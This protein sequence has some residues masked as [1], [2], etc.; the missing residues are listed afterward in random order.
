MPARRV[1]ERPGLGGHRPPGHEIGDAGTGGGMVNVARGLG[2]AVGVPAVTLA[3]HLAPPA[4][5][6][7]I[8]AT[9]S[10]DRPTRPEI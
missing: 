7:A 2:T 9:R 5:V 10:S 8:A 4:A 6:L 3:L 1:N